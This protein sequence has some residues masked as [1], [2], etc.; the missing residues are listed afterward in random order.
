MYLYLIIK[1]T[2]FGTWK[3]AIVSD[4]CNFKKFNEL[5]TM[6]FMGNDEI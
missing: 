2:M 3:N 1:I 4:Y 5:P 6:E